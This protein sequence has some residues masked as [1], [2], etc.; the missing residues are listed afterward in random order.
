MVCGGHGG[1]ALLSYK[2]GRKKR[3][4]C[5]LG[6]FSQTNLKK[7]SQH[8]SDQNYEKFIKIPNLLFNGGLETF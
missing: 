8:F 6:K 4:G 3:F 2:V 7:V 1:N 5:H